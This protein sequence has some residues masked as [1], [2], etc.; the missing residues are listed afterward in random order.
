[1]CF[2]C[3][4]PLYSQQDSDVSW[5][6]NNFHALNIMKTNFIFFQIPRN[7]LKSFFP[8]ISRFFPHYVYRQSFYHLDDCS[9]NLLIYC[10]FPKAHF[11]E[12][13]FLSVYMG[14]RQIK[15]VI[16][17]LFLLKDIS[18]LKNPLP[19]NWNRVWYLKRFSHSWLETDP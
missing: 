5:K 19:E 17:S 11:E 1:M 10:T 6:W 4:S 14:M 3:F 8:S 13:G 9:N 12:V 16:A 15:S 2:C 18:F 7:L